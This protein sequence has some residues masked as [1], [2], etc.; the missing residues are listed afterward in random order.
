MNSSGLP[1]NGLGSSMFGGIGSIE[2]AESATGV[3][4][5][6]SDT[7]ASSYL[8]SK[9]EYAGVSRIVIVKV[10]VFKALLTEL[11]SSYDSIINVYVPA[12]VRLGSIVT[13]VPVV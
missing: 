5:H 7:P 6:V 10:S 11:L 2:L 12:V 1:D 3:T 4:S 13:S 8:S 9:F